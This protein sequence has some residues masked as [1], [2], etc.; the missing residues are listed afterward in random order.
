MDFAYG[1]AELLARPSV[2][3]EASGDDAPRRWS[4]F[5]FPAW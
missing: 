3:R 2:E 5:A 1:V 4:T